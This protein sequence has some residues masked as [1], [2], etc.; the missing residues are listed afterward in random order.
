MRRPPPR[1]DREL[2]LIVVGE[3]NPDIVVSDPD[4]VPRFGQREK[5]VEGVTM[6]IGSSSAIAACGAARLG[7]RVAMVGVVGDDPFGRYMLQAMAERGID[8][9]DCRIDATTPTG[10]TVILARAEDRAILTALGTISAVS[11]SDISDDLLA[12]ARHLHVGSF[13]LQDRLADGVPELFRRAH[14]AGLT[15]SLDPNDDP[16]GAW[17]GGLAEALDETDVFFPNAA[18]VSAIGDRDDPIEAARVL[19]TR[20]DPSPVVVVKL[21]SDGGAVVAGEG[22]LERAPAFPAQP[23]D[24]IGAGDSFDAGF[25][26]GWLDGVALGDCLRMATV[27]GALSTRSTGGTPAQ[28]TRDELDRAL[29][30]WG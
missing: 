15:T 10:A 3:I 9:T 25:L 19:A 12:R 13:F 4:P 6:T 11:A 29:A 14:R 30:G 1:E 20:A 28:P 26:A 8:T 21:G 7:L 16:S 5:I 18:E 24:L 2:D 17:D 27:C 22:E 23:V